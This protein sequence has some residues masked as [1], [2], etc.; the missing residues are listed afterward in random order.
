MVSKATGA[1]A[2]LYK[3]VELGPTPG[4]YRVHPKQFDPNFL[5][6][7][8]ETGSIANCPDVP[9]VTRPSDLARQ[10]PAS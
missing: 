1:V 5:P 6:L 3:T 7:I 8:R 4:K 9:T 10:A 2:H